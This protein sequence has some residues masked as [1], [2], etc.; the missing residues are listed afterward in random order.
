MSALLA[1][2]T[3]PNICGLQLG[4]TR[5][6]APTRLVAYIHGDPHVR[7][8]THSPHTRRGGP[9]CPPFPPRTQNK[10]ACITKEAIRIFFYDSQATYTARVCRRL[11]GCFFRCT[12]FHFFDRQF[13]AATLIDIEHFHFNLL[14]FFQIVRHILHAL[15]G[16]LRNMHQAIFARQNRYKRAEIDDTCNG[17]FVD[18]D[19][20]PLPR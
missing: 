16:D 1:V 6:S 20:L 14:T 5:R 4:Q 3:V 9:T 2:R 19:R 7:R 10:I 11:L 15:V 13:D 8:G 12:T 17:A 18:F